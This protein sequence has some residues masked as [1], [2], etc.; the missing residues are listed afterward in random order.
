M[1]DANLCLIQLFLVKL[2]GPA[3]ER[4][5]DNAPVDQRAGKFLALLRVAGVAIERRCGRV[6]QR[7]VSH[8]S[9][10]TPFILGDLENRLQRSA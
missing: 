7:P 6:G 1:N 4:N 8:N 5:V 2:S 9:S 10:S 3:T